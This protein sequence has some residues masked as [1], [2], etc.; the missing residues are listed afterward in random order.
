MTTFD[1]NHADALTQAI[2]QRFDQTLQRLGELVAIPSVAWE[3]HDLSQVQRSAEKVRDLALAAGFENAAL[4]TADYTA[5]NGETKTGM[6]A[7]LASR[8]AAEGYPTI[9]LYAHHDV[10]PAGDEALWDTP[11]FE[12]V[13]KGDRLYGRGAADDKAGVLLHLA[14][15]EA[16]S[17]VL[18]DDFKL[19]IKLFIEGEE[20]AGSPSF[21][22]FVNTYR[23]QLNADYIVVADSSNW[24][25]GVPALTT[26]LRGVASGVIEARVGSHALHSGVFGGPLLDAHTVLA[27]LIATLHDE[28]GSV[29]IEGLSRRD[30]QDIVYA[31]SDFRADSGALEQMS[32]AGT[33]SI[34]SRLWTQPA[35]SVIGWDIPSVANSSNTLAAVS[36]AIISVRLAPGT[37]PQAAHAAIEAHLNQHAPLNAQIT[38]TPQDSGQPFDIDVDSYGARLALAAFEK[39]WG[40][41]PVKAGMGGSIPFIATL[42][43][44]F[45]QAQ[46]L[47][48]GIED[49]D[50]RAHSANESL[51]VPDL[52][53]GIVAEALVLAELSK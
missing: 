9:L 27:R 5:E 15:I 6:P 45:P 34:A 11:P 51:Y 4:Y 19:G 48:T 41:Q 44:V 22:S 12:T 8:P 7:V 25:A 37:D 43:Q 52:L 35:V 39:A 30:D 3:S 14:A 1:F 40:V 26:S 31:E 47:V 42:K 32:L 53:H 16:V 33:G 49:P 29:A 2:E 50:T 46:I 28:Q 24:R 36:R 21:E 10:Q 20:E 13:R 23:D 17:S 18:G 38:Y